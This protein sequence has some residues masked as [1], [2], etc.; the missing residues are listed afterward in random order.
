MAEADVDAEDG[1]GSE[2][3]YVEPLATGR[4]RRSTAGRLMN[5]LLDA[6][7]DDELARIFAEEE[8][9]EEFESGDD[10]EEGGE[11]A[12]DDMELDSSSSDEADDGPTAAGNDELEGEKE[13][14]RQEKAERAK[15]RTAQQ[16]GFRIPALRK[17][18]VK[19][20]P[21]LPTRTSTLPA[22]RQRKKSERI[23]WLPTADDGPTRVSSRRQT[24]QNRVQTHARLK[25]SEQKRVQLIA[26]MEETAKRKEKAK[27]K[28]MTQADRLAEAEKTERL[29]YGSLTRWEEM[30]E[31][32]GEE[33]RL[34]MEALHNRRLEG[35][36]ITFWSGIAKWINEKLA[37]VG[38][39]TFR[40]AADADS[41]RKKKGRDAGHQGPPATQDTNKETE[42]SQRATDT[43]PVQSDAPPTDGK[44]APQERNSFL[45][46]IHIYASMQEASTCQ[47]I[48]MPDATATPKPATP[49]PE[50]TTIPNEKT[51]SN[52]NTQSPLCAE[53]NENEE[54]QA[55]VIPVE[56][57]APP[58]QGVTPGEKLDQSKPAL[59]R[60][61]RT[62]IVLDNFDASTAPERSDVGVLYNPKKPVKLPKT[63]VEFCP[64][65]SRPARYRDPATGIPY[66]NSLAYRE[67]RQVLAYRY[68]WSGTFGCFVGPIGVGAR[69]VPERFL[70]PNAAPP[71]QLFG[72]GE[73][74]SKHAATPGN[75]P[76]A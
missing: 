76:T 12:A 30:E 24:M 29:N 36:V 31:K 4:A 47:D 41:G 51:P 75:N 68:A 54:E 73:G 19:I 35:P 16:E 55:A 50:A 3:Y 20:D 33:R 74:D 27:P 23:S 46:G 52:G 58:G 13:L 62:C 5:T 6:E 48:E 72:P 44:Q 59:E 15:K 34:K 61:S 65:T 18:K 14:Q 37:M 11:A 63:Q 56:E 67:I 26:T 32:R 60:A 53:K 70:A 2:S 64:I 17:K 22:P 39:K 49:A 57:A 1:S 45:D 40:Q 25:R 28:Q 9:D 38:V 21:T 71:Q 43:A 7:A 66:S 8:D 69:G 10:E 42:E